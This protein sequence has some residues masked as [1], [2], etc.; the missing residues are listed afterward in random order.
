MS[1]IN[2]KKFEEITKVRL[3]FARVSARKARFVIDAVRGKNVAE[4][5]AILKFT[6]RPSAAPKVLQLLKNAVDSAKA[7]FDGDPD[8]LV[9]GAI[10]AD[11]GPVM[12]RVQPA[13]F[14]RAFPIRKRHCHMTI[15]LA[16]EK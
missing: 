14:G 15:V 13:P 12:K 11:D 2:T 6:H 4:A 7:K 16:S 8:S 1:S 10:Y 9:I 3:R 5:M